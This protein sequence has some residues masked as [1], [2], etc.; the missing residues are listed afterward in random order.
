MAPDKP[1][2]SNWALAREY[3]KRAADARKLSEEAHSESVRDRDLRIEQYYL[4]LAE[5]EERIARKLR[6][7]QKGAAG[8][9]GEAET[10]S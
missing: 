4:E 9:D 8:S 2:L 7:P 10:P 5:V 6:A 1:G 3:R